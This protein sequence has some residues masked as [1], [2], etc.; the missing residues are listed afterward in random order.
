MGKATHEAPIFRGTREQHHHS[1]IGLNA[2]GVEGMP[3]ECMTGL[4]WFRTSKKTM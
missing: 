2:I 1:P 3:K 4:T